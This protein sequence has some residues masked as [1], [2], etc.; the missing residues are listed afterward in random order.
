M[1]LD[2]KKIGLVL[3]GGG[4]R[5]L[6]HIGVL[7]VFEKHKIPVN[8]IAGTSIGSLIGAFYAS[9]IPPENIEEIAT[10]LDAKLIH[11][12]F[13]PTLSKS[14]FINGENIKEFL[15]QLIKKEK[16]EDLNITYAAVAIDI[17]SGNEAVFRSGSL[18]EAV[19]ASISIPVLFTPVCYEKKFLVDGG[20]LNPVPVDVA[21]QMGADF[22]I[23]VNVIPKPEYAKKVVKIA[24]NEKF[25]LLDSILKSDMINNWLSDYLKKVRNNACTGVKMPNIIDIMIYSIQAAEYEVAKLKLEIDKPDVLIQ[26]DLKNFEFKDFGR[27]RELIAEGEKAAEEKIDEILK[28]LKKS[29]WSI[30]SGSKK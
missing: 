29:S 16:I 14:G 3:G 18:I 27:A 4:A 10:N 15:S 8:I 9:G 25:K 7:K 5:G 13:Q 12:L 22:I 6:A 30:F 23:A 28:K 2:K 11:K 26:P 24:V 17:L 1:F 20:L 19:R 21:E